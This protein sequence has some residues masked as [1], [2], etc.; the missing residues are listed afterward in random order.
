MSKTPW[1]IDPTNPD[2][3]GAGAEG[4]AMGRDS[5]GD[6]TLPPPLQPPQDVERTNP[7][8]PGAPST[9]YQPQGATSGP[10]HDGEVIEMSNMGAEEDSLAPLLQAFISES[11]RE[12]AVERVKR[13]TSDKYKKVD[14]SQF[15]PIGWGKK[16][17]NENEIVVIGP[18]GGETRIVKQDGSGLLKAFE[19]SYKKAL[20]PS[21]EEILA[22]ENQEVREAHQ[23]YKAK[24]EKN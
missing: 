11:E 23:K 10:Y 5:A 8:E 24:V 3:D 7:F 14:F 2:G 6:T 1:V 15:G 17:E 9:P 19:N 21:S 13:F 16:P 12:T 22:E 18:K 20:G 4:G